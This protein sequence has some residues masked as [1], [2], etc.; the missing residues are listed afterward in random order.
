MLFTDQVKLQNVRKL[1]LD[2]KT[3][4]GIVTVGWLLE[5]WKILEMRPDIQSFGL[6][7][8]FLRRH[9]VNMRLKYGFSRG[10]NRLGVKSSSEKNISK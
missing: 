7:I 5:C 3:V 6:Q 9:E 10:L 4:N 2:I 8:E 1:R